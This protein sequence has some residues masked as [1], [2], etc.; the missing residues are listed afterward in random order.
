MPK[1]YIVL[2]LFNSIRLPCSALLYLM[3]LLFCKIIII[4]VGIKRVLSLKRKPSTGFRFIPTQALTRLGPWSGGLGPRIYG[5][6]QTQTWTQTL[7]SLLPQTRTQVGSM[8][9]Q[10]TVTFMDWPD[11]SWA[12]VTW[13]TKNGGCVVLYFGFCLFGT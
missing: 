11:Q 9:L 8:T 12:L 6:C 2:S 3:N 7:Q 10:L 4:V 13:P 1:I 5:Q